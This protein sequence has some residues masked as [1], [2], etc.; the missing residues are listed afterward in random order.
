VH[1]AYEAKDGAVELALLTRSMAPKKTVF[2]I[3][4]DPN[5]ASKTIT[6]YK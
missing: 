1:E 4:P 2:V 5:D 3:S 6:I